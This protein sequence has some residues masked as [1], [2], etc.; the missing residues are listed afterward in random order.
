MNMRFCR[1]VPNSLRNKNIKRH[2]Q[3]LENWIFGFQNS[4]VPLRHREKTFSS[5]LNFMLLQ[6][7]RNE[8]II[9]GGNVGI[10]VIY[11][12]LHK[13]RSQFWTIHLAF[14][15]SCFEALLMENT[16]KILGVNDSCQKLYFPKH[17]SFMWE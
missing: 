14:N 1:Y 5:A 8:C 11:K 15:K 6:T 4:I 10:E 16:P 7:V 3:Y 12:T 17:L 13:K 9:F 2:I